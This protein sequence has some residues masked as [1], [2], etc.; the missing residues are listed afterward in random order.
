MPGPFPPT[1]QN[2]FSLVLTASLLLSGLMGAATAGE[3]LLSRAPERGGVG[4]ELQLNGTFE[5]KPPRPDLHKL[6]ER[7]SIIVTDKASTSAI[8]FSEVMEKLADDMHVKK[9]T[10][11]QR[12]WDTANKIPDGISDRATNVFCNSESEQNEVTELSRINGFPYECPREEGE[13]AKFDPFK[14]EACPGPCRNENGYTAIAISNRFD[15]ADKISGSHCGE[16]RIVFAKNSGF[17]RPADRNFIIFESLVPNPSPPGPQPEADPNNIFH[18]LRGCRPIVEFWLSLSRSDMTTEERGKSLHDFFFKGLPDHN[19]GAVVNTRH[20]AGGPGSGQIRT[21]QFMEGR[22][23]LREFKTYGGSIVPATVKSN[24]GNDLLSS[25]I[26]DPRKIE[27]EEYL[28][29]KDTLDY[30]RGIRCPKGA[31]GE[32]SVYCFAFGLTTAGLDH[33]NSFD[34]MPQYPR[35]GDVVEAFIS[36]SELAIVALK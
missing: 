32:N 29:A 9:N 26:P 1:S 36:V 8:T 33:L 18:N 30:L 4:L 27:L 22:W 14:N 17:T 31:A 7:L 16:F 35:E 23:T 3:G 5:G 10:L 2:A 28:V 19:I 34:S 6:D 24:P 21:N 15:L 12:W 20:Y 13:Q 11:F 25:S